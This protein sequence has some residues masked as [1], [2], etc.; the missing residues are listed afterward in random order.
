MPR[1][2]LRGESSD[3]QAARRAAQTAKALRE[4]GKRLRGAIGEQPWRSCFLKSWLWS[5]FCEGKSRNPFEDLVEKSL[6]CFNIIWWGGL[7]DAPLC[8]HFF[9]CCRR[10]NCASTRCL[11]SVHWVDSLH[12]KHVVMPVYKRISKLSTHTV[13]LKICF[14]F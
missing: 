1:D 5:L 3:S 6:I 8:I 4:R 11:G 9:I 10:F 12:D 14:P 2:A 7:T 13:P